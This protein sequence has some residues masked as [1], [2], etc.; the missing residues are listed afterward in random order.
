VSS[1]D[2]P[3]GDFGVLVVRR[4]GGGE[5]WEMSS[6]REVGAYAPLAQSR[7]GGKGDSA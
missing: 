4:R 3:P 7:G 5:R 2:S 6:P 1:R